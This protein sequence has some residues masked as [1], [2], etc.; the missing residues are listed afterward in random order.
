MK[1]NISS[2]TDFPRRVKFAPAYSGGVMFTDG[3]G[4]P[5]SVQVGEEFY[6][7]GAQLPVVVDLASVQLEQNI[8]IFYSHDG[9]S[10]LG[11]TEKVETDGKELTAEGL[12]ESPSQWTQEILQSFEAGAKWQCSI[13]SG[14]IEVQNKSLVKAG[15]TVEVNGRRLAGP[16]TLL[17]NLRVREISIV[18]AGADPETETLLA[19]WALRK[20]RNMSFEEWAASKGFDLAAIDDANRQALESMFHAGSSESLSAEECADQEKVEADAGTGPE[21]VEAEAGTDDEE[22]EPVGGVL[23]ASEGK[24]PEEE[25][26]EE[27]VQAAAATGKPSASRK[28]ASGFR[29]PGYFPSLNTPGRSAGVSGPQ[30]NEVPTRSEVLQCSALLNL[31][32]PAEWLA[33]RKGGEFSKRCVDAADRERDTSILS[34]MGEVLQASG[35]RPDYRRPFA[36]V[37]QFREVLQASGVSTKDFGDLNVFSPVLD[38][39]M[40]YK[41]EM[42]DSIWKKLYKKRVVPNFNAVATVDISIEG[43]AKDLLENEDFPVVMFKSSGQELRTKKQGIT[44]GISFESQINDDMGA[45]NEVGDELLKIIVNMQTRKFWTYFW[46]W[47]GSTFTGSSHNKIKKTLTIDGL[48]AARKAFR[49]MK[50][51]NGNFIQCLPM[52]LIVPLALEDKALEIFHSEWAGEATTRKNIYQHKYDVISDPYLGTDGGMTGATDTGWFLAGDTG[53]YPIGEYAVLSGFETP[54]IMKTWYDDKDAL[55][56]RALGT[57]GF[58]GYTDKLAIVYSDGTQS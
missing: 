8:P 7:A 5:E 13:G 23:A 11:H 40:R 38:K 9:M 12:L 49:S 45:L 2:N 6:P 16:F 46:S 17:K 27:K 33:S 37:S 22:K 56:Y 28:R 20:E 24:T 32:I 14:L 41:Y 4:I 36:I 1:I 43:N 29:T 52:N 48:A 54:K 25:K 15:E 55:M 34:I 31:G 57:I 39:Q 47:A 35:T 18:P 51:S 50:D 3:I 42:L 58:T 26:T 10:R 21:K 53:A 19:S 30:G 44:A